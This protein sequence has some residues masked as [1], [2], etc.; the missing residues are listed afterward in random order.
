MLFIPGLCR[1]HCTTADDVQ[2]YLSKKIKSKAM[3]PD[4]APSAD[5]PPFI[6]LIVPSPLIPFTN[7]SLPSLSGI[8]YFLFFAF[9]TVRTNAMKFRE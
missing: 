7:R 9:L 4:I 3:A 8:F 6:P 5:P 1:F 2:G